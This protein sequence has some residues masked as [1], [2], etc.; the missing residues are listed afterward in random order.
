MFGG[1][2]GKILSGLKSKGNFYAVRSTTTRRFLAKFNAGDGWDGSF[3][4]RFHGCSREY[5]YAV[6]VVYF[7][8]ARSQFC[9]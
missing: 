4:S 6:V 9:A 5:F 8:G 7:G 1:R 2:S 3:S